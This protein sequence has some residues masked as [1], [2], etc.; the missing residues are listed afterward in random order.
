MNLSELLGK[1]EILTKIELYESSSNLWDK[2]DEK[3]IK[4][5]IE[6]CDY[7]YDSRCYELRKK[8]ENYDVIGILVSSK[9]IMQITIYKG[10]D[11][12]G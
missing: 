2:D 4:D 7:Y 12:N 9:Y 1:V 6:V 5:D 8:Y 11:T 10:D 3:L